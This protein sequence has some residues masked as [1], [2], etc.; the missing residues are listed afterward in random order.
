MR[1]SV[2]YKDFMKKEATKEKLARIAA[3][4]LDLY[5][6][7]AGGPDHRD[8]HERRTPGTVRGWFILYHDKKSVFRG[9]YPTRQKAR[10]YRAWKCKGNE[11]AYPIVRGTSTVI[12]KFVKPQR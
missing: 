6:T 8:G 11:A 3:K 9:I 4:A 10:E 2:N 7:I 1:P 12:E 5:E